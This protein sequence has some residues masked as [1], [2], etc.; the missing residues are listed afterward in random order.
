MSEEDER[1]LSNSSH[2]GRTEVE[3]WWTLFVLLVPGMRDF[4]IALLQQMYYP[5]KFQ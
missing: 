2:T 1:K 3:T 4:D 5:C